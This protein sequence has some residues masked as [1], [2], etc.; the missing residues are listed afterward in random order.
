[1]LLHWND[2]GIG[3]LDRTVSELDSLRREMDRVF[4]DFGRAPGRARAQAR[5]SWPRI[6]LA[7]MG[8]ALLLT[9][10]VPGL[11]DKE[12]KIQVDQSTL[13]L[14][15]MRRVEAPQGYDV[16]RRERAAYEF[17]RSFTL[18][19]KVD[20]DLAKATLKNGLLTLT[21]PKAPEVQPRQIK[22]ATS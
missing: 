22:V 17:T 4:N 15:G 5:G 6:E 21:L 14:Q 9:A 7:D 3:D 19:V 20:A 11:T 2:F 8:S 10:E 18:P 13:T 16:H 1:M 12:L